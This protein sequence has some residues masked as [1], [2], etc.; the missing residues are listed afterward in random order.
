MSLKIQSLISIRKARWISCILST[1][2]L[3]NV[4]YI[5][6]AL[7]LVQVML[8]R[9]HKHPKPQNSNK[10]NNFDK[11][12]KKYFERILMSLRYHEWNFNVLDLCLYKLTM[13]YWSD[14]QRT[15]LHSGWIKIYTFFSIWWKPMKLKCVKSF[16]RRFHKMIRCKLIV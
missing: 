7:T 13:R 1:L 12:S 10:L 5:W 14:L 4:L 11:I 16:F 9:I 3:N 15:S 6:K 2:D 8:V